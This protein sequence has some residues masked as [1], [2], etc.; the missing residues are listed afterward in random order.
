MWGLEHFPVILNHLT[1]FSR[2]L[3]RRVR[4]R[5]LVDRERIMATSGGAKLG[6]EGS[7]KA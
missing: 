1:G 3:A 4:P 7:I 2:L 6:S 5:G